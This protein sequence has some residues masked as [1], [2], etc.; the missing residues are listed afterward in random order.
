MAGPPPYP[1]IPRWVKVFG[2]IV[3]VLVLL[4]VAGM[5]I[6][7]GEHGPGRHTPSGDARGP[8]P[9]S[10]VMEAQAPPEGGRG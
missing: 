5:F 6:G 7:G 9:P 3:I 2:S 8:V 1:G 4:I 10:S